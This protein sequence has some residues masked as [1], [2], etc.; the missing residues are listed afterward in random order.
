MR[1]T[2]FG[3]SAFTLTVDADTLVVDPGTFTAPLGRLARVAAVF[4][5]HAHPDHLDVQ[6]VEALRA[7]HRALTVFGTSQVAEACDFPVSIAR[8][9]ELA[10]IGPFRLEF[11]GSVHAE[12]LPSLPTLQNVGVIVNDV[13]FYPGDAFTVPASKPVIDVLIVPV[14]APWLKISEVEDYV[15]TL[16]PRR[17][18]PVHTGVLSE[19][20][21][22]LTTALLEQIATVT[23]AG[24]IR[25]SPG[26]SLEL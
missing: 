24:M 1:I 3:H 21:G 25:L 8:D 18:L 19:N 16:N 12:V 10:E 2:K 13:V 17:I 6:K 22:R 23:G 26:D 4:V 20:G 15:R 14:A 7:D 5:S 9:G 11:V